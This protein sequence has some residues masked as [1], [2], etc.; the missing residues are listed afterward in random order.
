MQT[1]VLNSA[2]D[3]T[4]A[5]GHLDS[6]GGGRNAAQ[7]YSLLLRACLCEG[8]GGGGLGGRAHRHPQQL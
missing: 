3:K 8:R 2:G 5:S 6:N 7:V 4:C 1:M